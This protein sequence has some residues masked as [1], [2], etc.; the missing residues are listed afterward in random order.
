[1]LNTF[2]ERIELGWHDHFGGHASVIREEAEVFE[3]EAVRQVEHAA[4]V[5]AFPQHQGVRA[6]DEFE[7]AV[8]EV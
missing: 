1:M 7:G 2:D 8:T 6:G 5:L 4:L 3:A